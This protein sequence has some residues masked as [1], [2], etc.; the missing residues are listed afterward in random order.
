[1][2]DCRS[3]TVMGMLLLHGWALPLSAQELSPALPRWEAPSLTVISSKR[4]RA[5]TA[6]DST[7]VQVGYQHWRYAAFGAGLG[8]V[9]GA[10]TGALV[11]GTETCDDCSSQHSAGH[12]ALVG[13]LLG[14]GLGGVFGFLTGLSHP[15]YAIRPAETGAP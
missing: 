3:I 8:G 11:E 14:A 2:V 4:I 1:M 5:L 10:L 13:G 15:K 9:I 12:G 7:R 6:T